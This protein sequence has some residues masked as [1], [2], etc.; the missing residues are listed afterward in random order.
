MTLKFLNL[1]LLAGLLLSLCSPIRATAADDSSE[2]PGRYAAMF[3]GGAMTHNSLGHVVRFDYSLDQEQLYSAELSYFFK[4]DQGIR[5]YFGPIFQNI[6]ANINVTYHDDHGASHYELIPYLSFRWNN[7]PWTESVRTSISL[8]EGVSW[9]SSISTREHRNSTDPQKLLN[10]LNF[11][12]T[13][14]LAALP[15]I[16]LVWR[17]HHRSGVFGLYRS[18]NSGSTAAGVGLRWYFDRLPG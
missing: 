14:A 18:N 10:Y 3:Y 13:A 12:L 5:R 8:G 6:A 11:E 17:F 1:G 7:F 9:I 15:Q 16:E 2:S 4:P